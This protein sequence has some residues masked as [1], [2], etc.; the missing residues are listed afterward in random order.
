[1]KKLFKTIVLLPMWP[2]IW[3][4]LGFKLDT[5]PTYGCGVCGNDECSGCKRRARAM[6]NWWRA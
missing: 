4:Q 1:M 5:R 3:L 2:L 6:V